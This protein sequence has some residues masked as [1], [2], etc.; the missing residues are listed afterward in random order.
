MEMNNKLR[1]YALHLRLGMR[2]HIGRVPSRR[3]GTVPQILRGM[4]RVAARRGEL[5]QPHNGRKAIGG[6]IQTPNA[7]RFSPIAT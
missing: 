3:A 1:H 4:V 2:L 6:P 5:A 7:S